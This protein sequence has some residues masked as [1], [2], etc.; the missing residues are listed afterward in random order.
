MRKVLIT[1]GAGFIGSHL[2]KRLLNKNYGV[3]VFDNLSLGRTEFLEPYL[4]NPLF[5]F[6]KLDLLDKETLLNSMRDDIYTV[7]HLAANS[8]ISRGV[9]DTSIDFK[10]T[11]I[12]TY[13]LLEAMRIKNI[14]KIFYLSGSGVYGDTNGVYTSE[15][16]GPLC[17]V[18][19]YG[20]TKLSAEAMIFAYAHLFDMQVF[21]LRPAN[22]IGP[23]ATHGVIFDFIKRLRIDPGHLTI[24]GDGK[25]NK[26]YLYV[27]DVIDAVD[28]VWGK[29][30][31]KINIYNIASNSFISVTEIADEILR[32]MNLSNRTIIKYTG[33]NIGWKGDVP[34]VRIKNTK[35]RKLG[36]KNKYTSKQAVSKTVK[37]LLR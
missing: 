26:S 35:I 16:Y 6:V 7:F 22:I 37:E 31:E 13:N 17:P 2:I 8:D 18:S 10:N 21:M 11:T 15:S 4:D 25:Q 34:I 24:L 36:W 1:G 33:G 3:I 30:R 23:R 5:S 14:K 12:S 9:S 19:M 28:L 29:P 20:A 32:Q 27:N